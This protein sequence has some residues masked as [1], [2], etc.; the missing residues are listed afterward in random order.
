[1]LRHPHN[2]AVTAVIFL[3]HNG[4]RLRIILCESQKQFRFGATERVN[5]LVVIPDQKQII[6][7]TCKHLQDFVLHSVHILR[8][9]NEKVRK[10]FPVTLQ[11]LRSFD[12]NAFCL[13]Q[14]IVKIDLFQ[15][16]LHP[17]ILRVNTDE[18]FLRQHG[19]FVFFG[20]N[21]GI[22]NKTD[23]TGQAV[24]IISDPAVVDARPYAC[25]L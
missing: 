19:R 12:Q 23:L 2:L 11:Y 17:L 14:H 16:L 21:A 5:R 9:I 24:E 20:Q 18:F 3:Q 22:L 1:M 25:C 15:I 8:L 13:C 7:R 6:P 4:L 10:P